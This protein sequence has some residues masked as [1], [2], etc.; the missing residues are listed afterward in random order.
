MENKTV[1]DS[2]IWITY[3]LKGKFRELVELVFDYDV[4]LFRCIELTRELVEVLS[5]PKFKKYLE[6][7]LREYISFY[8]DLSKIKQITPVFKGCRDSKDNYLFDLAYQ[9]KSRF[10]V[11]GDKD[12]RETKITKPLEILSLTSFKKIIYGFH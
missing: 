7:P 8:E 5:R 4:E 6:L 1:F 11:S 12:V 10:L 2:N 3:F 9:S